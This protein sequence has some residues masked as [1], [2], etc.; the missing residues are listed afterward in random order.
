[1]H[2]Y[3]NTYIYIYTRVSSVKCKTCLLLHITMLHIFTI[4]VIY[5]TSPTTRGSNKKFKRPS[6]SVAFDTDPCKTPCWPRWPKGK[7][8]PAVSWD[9]VHLPWYYVDLFCFRGTS[10]DFQTMLSLRLQPRPRACRVKEPR[11]KCKGAASWL[12]RW[13]TNMD[14]STHPRNFGRQYLV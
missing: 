9:L 7:S 2:L 13:S 3:N 8:S 4:I 10:G 14:Y 6:T 11:R 1:M 12:P 5:S